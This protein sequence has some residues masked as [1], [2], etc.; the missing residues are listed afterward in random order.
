MSHCLDRHIISSSL[1]EE[2]VARWIQDGHSTPSPHPLKAAWALLVSRLSGVPISKFGFHDTKANNV[3]SYLPRVETWMVSENPEIALKDAAEDHTEPGEETEATTAIVIGWNGELSS[4]PH[5]FSTIV[6]LNSGSSPARIHMSFSPASLTANRA[7]AHLGAL[8]RILEQIVLTPDLPLSRVDFLGSDGEKIIRKWNNPLSLL[9]PAVCIHTLIWEHCQSQPEAEALCAWDG[10]ISYAELDQL[11]LGLSRLLNTRGVCAEATV[12]LLFEKSRWTVIAILAVLRAGGAFVLLDPSHPVYRLEEICSEV[13]ATVVLT[14]HSFHTL[15]RQIHRQSIA[16]PAT[17]ITAKE[18]ALRDAPVVKSSNAAYIAFT[19]GST[20]KPKGIVIEHRSFCANALSQ[21][22]AQ[23]LC[24]GV[25]AFQ[26]AAHA[27]DSSILEMLMTLIAGGC[28]CIPSDEQRLNGL[29]NAINSLQANWLELTPSVARL[30]DPDKIPGVKSLLLVGEPMSP[31]DVS[32]WANRVHLLNAYGPAECS[33]VTTIQNCVKPESPQNIGRSYSS[34]CWV[35]NP[36]NH[37]QLEPLGAVG[38]LIV[39]GPIVARGYLNTTH[40]TSFMSPPRWA[41]RFSIHEDERFYRTGDL[42]RYDADNDTLHYIGRKDREVKIHGQRIDLQEIEHL[43]NQYQRQVAAVVD[44]INLGEN[45][46]TNK[47]L[48]MFM[49][50]STTGISL[51][52]K[53]L[54]CEEIPEDAAMRALSKDMK[55]WL[56]GRLPSYMIPTKYLWVNQFPLTRTDKLDRRALLNIGTASFTQKSSDDLDEKQSNTQCHG[57]GAQVSDFSSK[58]NLLQTV[59]AEVLGRSAKLISSHDKFYEL[60]GNSLAAIEVVGRAG[61][62]GLKVAVAE[63]I[64]SQTPHQIARAAEETTEIQGILPFSLLE[65][66]YAE[67]ALSVAADQCQVSVND[68]ED[69]YPCTP[70]QEGFMSMASKRPGAFIGTYR[71]SIPPPTSVARLRGAWERLWMEHPIL[72][73]RIVKMKNETLMQVVITENLVCRDSIHAPAGQEEM[74]IGSRLARITFDTSKAPVVFIL[75][76]HHAIFDGWTYLQL[77][78]DL[79][80]LYEDQSLS[81][82]PPFTQYIKYLS[83]SESNETISF[84]EKELDGYQCS[85]FPSSSLRRP[86]ASPQWLATSHLVSL[87]DGEVDWKLANQIKLAWALVISSETSSNDIVY[88][89]TTNG[90]SAPVPGIDRM[91]GP[92]MT[93]FPFRTQLKP[94]LTVQQML[95]GLQEHDISLMPYEHTGL[96]GIAESGPDSAWACSF[97]NLL[98]IRLQ[99]FQASSSA[100]LEFPEN[101]A[102]DLN[103]ASYPLSIVVQMKDSALELKAF[104]DSEILIA[105]VVQKLLGTLDE[106]LQQIIRRPE[107]TIGNLKTIVSQQWQHVAQVNA[108]YRLP[109]PKCIH[110]VIQGLSVTQP[111]REAVCAWDG[112]FTYE[113]L[114]TLGRVLAGELQTLGSGPNSIVGICLERSRLFPVAILGVLMSGAAIV[115]LEPGFPQQRLNGIL[116]DVDACVVVCSPETQKKFV[117]LQSEVSRTIFQLA[118]DPKNWKRS[119]P[120]TPPSVGPH[121][122]IYVAYTSG[123]TG[124]PKGVVIEHGMVFSTVH[125]HK[126]IIGAEDSSRCLLFASPAFDICLAEIFFMLTTGGCVCIP[127]ETQRTNNLADTMSAMQVNMAMLTPSVART[128]SPDELPFLRTLILGGEAPSASDLATWAPRVRLHQSYG[129]AECTMYSATTPPLVCN[130]VLNNVGSSPNASYWIVNPDDHHELMPMGSAGEL[131]IGGPLV[132]RGYIKRPLESAAVFIE[133]PVWAR[134][135]PNILETKLYK[136]GD[137]AILNPDKSLILLGR[138]DTQVKLHGQRIELHE[139][140]RCAEGLR[141]DIAV[142]VELVKI[143]SVQSS[144]LVAF[145]YD[146]ATVERS[147]GLAPSQPD[148]QALFISPSKSSRKLF[149]SLRQHLQKRLAPF[150]VPAIMLELRRLPLSPTGKIDRKA[151]RHAASILEAEILQMYRGGISVSK[152]TPMTAQEQLVRASF[153]IALGLDEDTLGLDDN[154]FTLGGDS[155]TAMRV[156]TQCKRAGISISM[157]EFLSHSTVSALCAYTTA[158]QQV[159]PDSESPKN[160]I[161]PDHKKS[162]ESIPSEDIE[163]DRELIKDQLDSISPNDI[164]AIYPCSDAHNGILELYTSKYTSTAIFQVITNAS[165]SAVK[166]KDAW[167]QLVE[168]HETLRTILV[169][170]PKIDAKKLHVVLRFSPEK[171]PIPT[172]SSTAVA[173]LRSIKPVQSW[174]LCPSHRIWI[175]Q[176]KCGQVYMRLDTGG[177]LVD[178]LSISILIRELCLILDGQTLQPVAV[179]YNKYLKH[180]RQQKPS[181]TKSLQ[182]WTRV[183]HGAPSSYL[184]RLRVEETSESLTCPQ[185]RARSCLLSADQFHKLNAFWKTHHFTMTN[186]CQLAWALTLDHYTCASDVCF[187]TIT[188]GRD[189]PRIDVWESVGSFFNVLPCRLLLNAQETCLEALFRN[190]TEIQLRN[191]HQNCSMPDMVRRSRKQQEQSV[192]QQTLFNT[193]LTIQNTVST[194]PCALKA[195]GHTTPPAASETQIKLLELKD[196]TEYDFCVAVHAAPSEIEVELRYWTSTASD[197]YASEIL[198][199]MIRNLDMIVQDATKPLA[200]FSIGQ[201]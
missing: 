136:T 85:K 19:S 122:P 72:R 94:D 138:K 113:E 176:D 158:G 174:D 115:L 18:S 8:N 31:S 179:P 150:M 50:R 127:S 154:F 21:N 16:V 147:L 111:E 170:N 110:D 3:K 82:R 88:G 54:E 149:V 201:V 69:I 49:S 90:R 52:S 29:S 168:R 97:G 20:G 91:A 140:E 4:L 142:I 57:D 15:G 109:S 48:I 182:Y 40:Q 53:D 101:E 93:T 141:N 121:D 59:F 71:F 161:L 76:I 167:N 86:S 81:S 2:L 98:T 44:V 169:D 55:V 105:S 96:K 197:Q 45:S 186:V 199:R 159:T 17:G 10:S 164:E 79:H 183:L 196:P 130:S 137:L 11:S 118:M 5:N 34:H 100:F 112:S 103:F 64:R 117:G 102:E 172:P 194:N 190:Q 134:Q 193:V 99:S 74:G 181:L 46:S 25:R 66:S 187:G 83:L 36:E 73:T 192:D 12:P 13:K 143:E 123:S 129:P 185:P 200:I 139:I 107:S 61:S 153:A 106:F 87:T 42:V 163:Y 152:K 89:L 41:T 80:T 62:R 165:V 108:E 95:I 58:E 47:I 60:G 131:L 177:A 22:A 173:D 43:A 56:Q 198:A 125:A 119:D 67:E 30:L 51:S 39:S 144:S 166:V 78:E 77:L 92:T 146:P 27:F 124:T 116:D 63:I 151:L 171:Q 14:S 26:F 114:V 184:P 24:P 70:L 9:R 162:D 1:S 132:G 148:Y 157:H 104:Y 126:D 195:Q 23:D 65:S 75:T 178:A 35:V 120:W 128:L 180:L 38:E 28:V 37:D 175:R 155:L 33:V 135:I 189:H 6:L 84:W 188:T 191:E 160:A 68:I 133:N 145:I 156:L 7:W 32:K